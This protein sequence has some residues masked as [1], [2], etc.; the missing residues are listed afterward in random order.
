MSVPAPVLAS[1]L[2]YLRQ[3]GRA[4]GSIYARRRALA[5]MG[6]LIGVPLLEASRSDL[7]R[8]RAGLDVT[9]NTVRSYVAHARC[10]YRWAAAEQLV[11]SDPTAGLLVPR[12][13]RG[14][15]RPI[16]E[17]DLLAA[18]ATAP[19]RIRGMLVLAGWAGFRACEIAFLR[20]D[21]VLDHATPP[22]L[23]VAAD[24]TKGGQAHIVP[25]SQFVVAELRAAGLPRA[26]Y[27]FRR[28]DGRPGPNTPAK[29]SHLANEHLIQWDATLHMLRH[30][31]LTALYQDTLD[32]RLTQEYAGHAD[33]ASTAIYTAFA[34]ARGVA[35]PRLPAAARRPREFPAASG[36]RARNP[37]AAVGEPTAADLGDRACPGPRRPGRV[38]GVRLGDLP[39]LRR[40]RLQAGP[41]R[42]PVLASGLGRPPGCPA[43]WPGF[44]SRETEKGA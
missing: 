13:I 2:E 42:L 16:A 34:S 41:A 8:W 39:R 5:R 9:G 36:L 18:L 30:R 1:H 15:P 24:A 40:L 31:F 27:V 17:R 11:G 19:G 38:R 26:G 4:E 29:I 14:L 25:A 10:F 20:R 37:D 3:L 6:I 22:V 35:G 43:R 33:P 28:R 7:A 44:I 21:R 32:L 12:K 23:V